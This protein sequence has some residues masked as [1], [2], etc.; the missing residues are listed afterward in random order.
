[1][2]G[3]ASPPR[4]SEDHPAQTREE[5][6]RRRRKRRKRRR[7]KAEKLSIV[8]SNCKGFSSKMESIKRDIIENR[9][10]DVLLL[11][12]TLLRGER[13]IKMKNYISFCKNRSTEKAKGRKEGGG[14]GGVATLVADHLKA[15][16]T[17]VGEGKEGDEYLITRL[18]QTQPALN[19]INFYGGNESRE[20]ERK[21]MESWNRLRDDIA[22]IEERGE[23]VLLMGDMNRAVG[24]DELGIPGNKE[25]VSKGGELIREELLKDGRYVLI[26]GVK[27]G[28]VE[29]GP[30]TW[31]QPGK[32]ETKSCLDIAIISSA[33]L[34][35]VKKLVIDSKK[36]F[37]P[38]RVMRKKTGVVSI[39]TDHFSLELV[40][41][42]LPTK[43]ST[44]E[45][46]SRWNL[47]KP[48]G[49]QKYE[50]L[51]EE[52]AEKIMKVAKDEELDE[53]EVMKNVDA[54][55]TKVKF[56]AFGKTKDTTLK[57]RVERRNTNDE[58]LLKL[59]GKAMEEEIMKVKG[60]AKDGVGRVYKM[61]KRMMGGKNAGQEPT[62]IRNP[63]N[64]E[65]VVSSEEIKEVTL[66]YCVDNLKNKREDENEAKVN[67]IRAEVHKKRMESKEVG[68]FEMTEKDFEDVLKKFKKKDTKSYDFLLKANP[69]FQ[70]AIFQVC[71]RFIDNEKFPE[72]FQKTMLYMISKKKGP[73][74]ILKNNRF[75]HM[76]DYLARTCEAL[77]V[78]RMRSTIFESSSIFQIGGQSGH[79]PEEHIFTLKS[80][81]EQ[82]KSQG[83]GI[84][85]TLVDIVS[86]FDRENIM[87]V[88]DTLEEMNVNK[89]ACRVWFKMNEETEIVVK[90]AVGMTESRKVGALVGQGSSGAAVV[91]QAMIDSGL[92]QYFSSSRDEMYYGNVRVES[93]AFQDDICKPCEDVATTQCGMTKMAM[94]LQERGLDAHPEKT[95]Y[96]VF[97]SEE[98]KKK[99]E[100]EEKIMP[101]TFGEFVV[102]AKK[103]DKYLGQILHE[104]GLEESVKAT[105]KERSAKVKGAI[106]ATKQ[107]IDTFQMQAMGGMMAAKHLWEGAIIPS[108]LA[109]AGTWIG[110]TAEA[111]A[112]CDQLQ[113]L[114]W[115]V[116]FELPSGT[117]KVMLTAETASLRMKQRIWLQKLFLAKKILSQG[118]SL[119]NQVY[120]EQ[121]K[122][123][124][125]GLSA[126]VEQICREIGVENVNEKVVSRQE[127][128]TA[129]EWHNI[130]E[131]KEDMEKLKKL[132][133][134]RNQDFRKPQEYMKERSVEKARQAFRVRSKMIK[135]VKMNFKN[136]HKNDLKCVKCGEEDE[137]QEHVLVCKEWKD[138]RMDLNMD[139][140]NDQVTFFHR[141]KLEK[142]RMERE[143]RQ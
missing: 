55:E 70:N 8:L 54:I 64:N 20:G 23:G 122:M 3:L 81:I 9:S 46:Q 127:L 1:M 119:A 138:F 143:G 113:E 121:L 126:E 7:K 82:R 129:V 35:Y 102:K 90:T 41:E 71:K 31:T 101:L 49:W 140:I 134:V 68:D 61:K 69:K 116:I 52:A 47:A 99:M 67:E 103:S 100:T 72:K 75:I 65:L 128:K 131:A 86:F 13:K 33:L 118:E 124:W 22:N 15:G 57:K 89:K 92:K 38:R 110:A 34:P 139:Q 18:G 117:P 125:G 6:R 112:M 120:K 21:V 63:A 76:K 78:N 108:L 50:K 114:F 74:E 79:C 29:G 4:E 27:T 10:P 36:M 88:M 80:L 28:L 85:L 5:Q 137:T 111:E 42:G 96:I 105:I 37:T 39:Y 109:G 53:E 135:S 12:E 32:E 130:K 62:A 133:G 115:R 87:D 73:A 95:S 91:S 106:Y 26:N 19:I 24:S 132:A 25:L 44:G 136:L 142:A 40:L 94:M 84:I 66:K 2:E 30:W 59:Q 43:L 16:L 83:R 141:L 104:D 77:V 17:K 58:E 93:A 45:Q 98:Y 123:G 51:T 11:N 48:G 14:G 107:I 60:E 97:G 56:K